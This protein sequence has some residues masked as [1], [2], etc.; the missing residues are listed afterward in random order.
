M[1]PTSSPTPNNQPPY[2][3]NAGP[4]NPNPNSNPYNAGPSTQSDGKAAAIIAYFGLIGLIIA[5]VLNSSQKAALASYHIRQSVGLLIVVVLAYVVAGIL[6]AISGTLGAI[7]FGVIGLAGLV[8]IILGVVAAASGE[9]KP[10]PIIG[11]EIQ[12]RLASIG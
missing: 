10:L 6:S 2:N 9:Q 12:N 7:L 5:F 11:A 4:Y 3:P 8:F 1:E